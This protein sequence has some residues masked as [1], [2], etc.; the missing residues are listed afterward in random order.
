MR[1]LRALTLAVTVVVGVVVANTQ[2][3]I[4]C[5]RACES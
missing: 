3:I 2:V 4:A 5:V 1:L